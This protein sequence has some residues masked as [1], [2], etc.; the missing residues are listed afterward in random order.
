VTIPSTKPTKQTKNRKQLTKMSSSSKTPPVA[1]SPSPPVKDTLTKVPTKA[2]AKA[3][4]VI[5]RAMG[6]SN[7]MNYN[8]HHDWILCSHPTIP[9][10]ALFCQKCEIEKQ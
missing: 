7:T 10:T 6:G 8:C 4:N 2:P 5:G 9:Y 1:Q 3:P